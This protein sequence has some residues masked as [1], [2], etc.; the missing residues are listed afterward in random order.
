MVSC[1]GFS[2]Q[3]CSDNL[4]ERSW[5]FPSQ[6]LSMPG[7][8]SV[9]LPFPFPALQHNTGTARLGLWLL[10]TWKRRDCQIHPRRKTSKGIDTKKRVFGSLSLQGQTLNDTRPCF[11]LTLFAIFSFLSSCP[12]I[13]LSKEGMDQTNLLSE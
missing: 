3:P 2:T 7:S 5:R 4:L 13:T 1:A 6:L 9:Q 10:S 12:A 8:G 11:F